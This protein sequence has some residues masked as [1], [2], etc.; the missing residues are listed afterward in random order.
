[1]L[2]E[3]E[4]VGPIRKFNSNLSDLWDKSYTDNIYSLLTVGGDIQRQLNAP[5]TAYVPGIV[6]NLLG[7]LLGAGSV[8]PGGAGTVL[9]IG[10][11]VFSFDKNFA[12]NK[13]GDSEVV[14]ITTTVANLG[15]QTQETFKAQGAALGTMFRFIYEDWGKIKAL[16][17]KLNNA[18]DP[19]WAWDSGTNSQML[20]LMRR[21]T[22]VSY[23]RSI[24]PTVHAV[25]QIHN[26]SSADAK[27][28]RSSFLNIFQTCQAFEPFANFASENYLSSKEIYTT[29]FWHVQPLGRI[30][31]VADGG[32]QHKPPSD[33]KLYQTISPD[34]LNK[35]FGVGPEDLEVYK[36]AFYR[37]WEFRHAKCDAKGVSLSKQIYIDSAGCDWEGAA[38]SAKEVRSAVSAPSSTNSPRIDVEAV[39][40]AG[41]VTSPE[42]EGSP[43]SYSWQ[44]LGGEATISNGDTATPS[45]EFTSG[46][47]SYVIRVTITD[48]NGRSS[49]GET[50]VVYEEQ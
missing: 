36:P 7:S 44:V 27:Y 3:L 8:L 42:M 29:D 10:Y 49:T 21:A 1:M 16:G 2:E 25:G 48:S 31:N 46:P 22:E 47:G 39:T 4:D 33:G 17:T 19:G 34:I 26:L 37:N 11:A 13:A 30:E 43:L 45:V 24:L 32:C 35:L 9:G 5:T 14:D 50:T 18:D 38:P 20:G 15:T 28:Y 23:Y 12:N 6:D 41:A 40:S